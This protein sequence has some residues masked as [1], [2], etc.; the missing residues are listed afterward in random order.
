M[1]FNRPS[2]S[3]SFVG[4]KKKGVY[5]YLFLVTND[6]GQIALARMESDGQGD[7]CFSL[8]PTTHRFP[9]KGVNGQEIMYFGS[10]LVNQNTDKGYMIGCDKDGR[11]YALC[12][13]NVRAKE[14]VSLT[15]YY[16]EP[17]ENV[18]YTEPVLTPEGNIVITGGI[19]DSNFRPYSSVYMLC[20]G[21][22]DAEFCGSMGLLP[23]ILAVVFLIIVALL[24]LFLFRKR[25]KSHIEEE[26]QTIDDTVE[27]QLMDR[28]CQMMEQE[29][30]FLNSDLKLSD[31]SAVLSTNSRYVSETIRNQ[32]QT[33]FTQFVN[34]YRVEHAKKL[35]KENTDRKIAEIATLSGFSGESSF[36]RT[37]KSF[38]GVTP[39][40]WIAQNV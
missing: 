32:R 11:L 27:K 1:L 26:P 25:R 10:V 16:S 18:G 14:N 37:F 30:L 29:K 22:N 9:M 19:D 38:T 4:D 33:S 28:I 31:V 12:I 40:E 35:M 7:P 20:L 15:L 8:L 6:E 17:Q 5:A 21:S 36:F 3:V 34:G 2:D 13:N 23:W 24:S 39:K